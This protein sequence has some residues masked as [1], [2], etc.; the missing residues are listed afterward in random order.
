M[1]YDIRS[2]LLFFFWCDANFR[3]T[4]AQKHIRVKSYPDNLS[5][6]KIDI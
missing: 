3:L 6:K 4:P 5:G 1:I 2:I